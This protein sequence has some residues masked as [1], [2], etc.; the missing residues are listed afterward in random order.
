[1][2]QWKYLYGFSINGSS[3]TAVYDAADHHPGGYCPTAV[4]ISL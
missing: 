1:M 3:K 2:S 4:K